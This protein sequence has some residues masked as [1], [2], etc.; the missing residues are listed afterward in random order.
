MLICRRNQLSSRIRTVSLRRWIH[1][2]S[3]NS[4]SPARRPS[5]GRLG[6]GLFK[7]RSI[8]GEAL[9]RW[10]SFYQTCTFDRYLTLEGTGQS[11]AG[12]RLLRLAPPLPLLAASGAG[13]ASFRRRSS[14]SG[15]AWRTSCAEGPTRP[16]Y[17]IGSGASPA[18]ILFCTS[19]G[20]GGTSSGLETWTLSSAT[21]IWVSAVLSS[22]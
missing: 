18:S 13:P 9:P 2:L 3:S 19:T 14:S 5:S 1:E 15:L 20:R 17:H 7:G 21:G 11:V 10:A 22:G 8:A 12:S 16:T 4:S 6:G